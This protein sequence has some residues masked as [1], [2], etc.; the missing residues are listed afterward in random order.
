MY[1]FS[2]KLHS[3][4]PVSAVES[5][6]ESGVKSGVE[7]G[8]KSA[9]ES[10]VKSGVKSGVESGVKSGVKS[11]DP[12]MSQLQIMSSDDGLSET[13]K[14]EVTV[15]PHDDEKEEVIGK[16]LMEFSQLPSNSFPPHV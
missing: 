15:R 1:C 3:T 12:E 7:S 14:L 16:D 13:Q 5:G 2:P 6:V 11:G 9:V 8:V 4:S 10:G